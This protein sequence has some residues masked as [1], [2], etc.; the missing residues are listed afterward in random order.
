MVLMRRIACFLAAAALLLPATPGNAFAAPPAVTIDPGNFNS[1]PSDPDAAMK[2]AR[3]R[4]AAGNLLGAITEL[5]TYVENHPGEA[6]PERLLG[7]LYYR[8]G[9]LT[10]AEVTYKHILFYLPADKETHNRLGSVYATEDRIQDAI[11]EFDRS[12]P[13]TD[14]VPDLVRLH[15]RRGDIDAYRTDKQ[16]IAERNPTDAEAQLEI[17][18]IYEETNVPEVAIRYFKRVLDIDPASVDALNHLGLAYHDEH[19]YTEAIAQYKTCMQRDAFNYACMTNLAGTYLEMSLNAQA[20]TLLSQARKIQPERGEA[21]VDLGYLADSRGDWKNAIKY[22]VDAITVYPYS[23]EPYIDLGYTYNA[24]HQYQL[25]EAALIKGLA[26]AP[27]DGRLHFLLGDAYARQG[28]DTLAATQYRAAAV[29][30]NLDA[31]VRAAA[32]ER[33]AAMHRPRPTPTP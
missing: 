9:E 31:G 1:M 26:I 3:E 21:L 20:E 23:P 8:R 13:G 15:I 12:L 30:K 17:G 29:A 14:S 27:E 6:G 18:V 2:R 24:H 32:Q 25:A 22:Y 11:D 19:R 4:V 10:R 7:D 28:N 33:V 5:Q 16:N